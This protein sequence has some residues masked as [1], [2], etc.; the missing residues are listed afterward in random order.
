VLAVEPKGPEDRP[1]IQRAEERVGEAERQHSYDRA[2]CVPE[3][4]RMIDEA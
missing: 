2:A 1:K 4:P 3:N